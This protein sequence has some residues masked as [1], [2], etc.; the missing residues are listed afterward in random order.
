MILQTL[1]LLLAALFSCNAE[2]TSNWAVLVSTSRFWFNYRHV[3][4]VLSA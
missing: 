3:A 2:H 4:N 1:P